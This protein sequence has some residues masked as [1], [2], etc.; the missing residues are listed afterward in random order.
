M[1][2]VE[3]DLVHVESRLVAG[4]IECPACPD[5][6]LGGWGFARARWVAGVR[7]GA[8][9]AGP[10]PVVFGDARVVAGDGASA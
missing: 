7:A 4:Q 1:V 8:S 6:V 9:T 2:T 5:G 3:A 10:M